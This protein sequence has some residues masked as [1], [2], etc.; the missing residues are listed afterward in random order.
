MTRLVVRL[1]PRA[2]ADR[3][4]GW[5]RDSRGRPL[6][7]VRTT[8]T[9]VDG[10]ANAALER[11]VARAL[12]IPPSRVRLVSGTAA[13]IKTLELEGVEDPDLSRLGAA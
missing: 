3:I 11:I 7:Q 12:G 9:P 10:K 4:E 13:R 6:L 1:T 2:E 5:S 8:A